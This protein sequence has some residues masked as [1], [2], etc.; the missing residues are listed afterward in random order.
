MARANQTKKTN[1]RGKAK[2]KPESEGVD[3][4]IADGILLTCYDWGD[5]QTAKITL[6]NAF[7]IYA[8]IIEYEDR[9]FLS[10]PSHKNNKGKYVN[11]AY[12]FDKDII[13]EINESVYDFMTEK[14]E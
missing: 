4:I 14:I 11:D 8:S 7:V 12:C 6:N 5:R 10:Y 9:Y 13:E 1:T 3:Y 2:P